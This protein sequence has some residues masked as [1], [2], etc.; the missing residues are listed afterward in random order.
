MCA[1]FVPV[2]KG[3]KNF[4]RI[5]EGAFVPF[6]TC[7]QRKRKR[8]QIIMLNE[9]AEAQTFIQEK[10]DGWPLV[11]TLL[12]LC[13]GKLSNRLLHQCSNSSSRFILTGRRKQYMDGLQ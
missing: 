6:F 9:F 7:L 8:G 11:I 4:H 1:S 12:K 5:S 3:I 2:G 13:Q 10:Q